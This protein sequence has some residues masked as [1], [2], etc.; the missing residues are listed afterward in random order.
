MLK[1]RRICFFVCNA[2]LNLK[3]A[4]DLADFGVTELV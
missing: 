4:P 1:S 3:H 2:V